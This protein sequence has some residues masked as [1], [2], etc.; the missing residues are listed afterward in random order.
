[1]RHTITFDTEMHGRGGIT[2]AFLVRGDA[3]ALVETGPRSSVGR[4][5]AQLEDAGIRE[6]D[7]I[8]VTHVH[9]D[10]AG[11]AG[12]LARHFPTARVAVHEIGAPHLVDPSKLWSSATRIYGGE[13][14]KLWGGIDPIPEHR[15]EPLADGDRIDLGGRVLQAVA[16]PGHAS[17]HHAFL[18]ESTGTVFA[19]DAL[20][21]RLADVGA[22]RPATP[23]PEF[24]LELAV[25]SIERIRGLGAE[26]LAFTH[27]G[28]TDQG[29]RPMGVGD[30][31]DRAVEALR[32]WCVW[33]S[34]ARART[35]DLDEAATEVE[36][37]DR[38]ARDG[39]LSDEAI[40]RLEQT[41]SYRMN[42]WGY[43][44]YLDKLERPAPGG[45]SLR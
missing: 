14:E 10:H 22:I 19:G 37:L 2:A 40:E 18:D 3:T 45:P 7:H 17:H 13:M 8:V 27:Y 12:T 9:L 42:T 38:A 43:M 1:M 44:R 21:V 31:C 33:V 23:P 11:A 16:T 25:R 20:G 15:I 6:L 24:D 29:V 39:S 30:A 41:T 4:V 26:S 36:R 34:D 5:L 32:R 35:E 28:P